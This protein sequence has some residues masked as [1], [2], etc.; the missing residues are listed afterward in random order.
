M[1]LPRILRAME[2]LSVRCNH[3]G[4]PL[5]VG[6][7][8]RFITCQFCQTQ[9]EVKHTSSAAFTEVIDQIAQKTAQMADNLKVIELQ[10][11]IDRLDREMEEQ[12]ERYYRSTRRGDRNQPSPV[13]AM[14]GAFIAL[15]T[16]A[17]ATYW[18]ATHNT[19]PVLP[20]VTSCIALLSL[21]T[22]VSRLSRS[23]RLKAFEAEHERK[24][25]ALMEQIDEARSAGR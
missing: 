19:P 7:K 18:F 15:P 9:L 6:E 14:V 4:A 10:N 3:C 12:R 22:I 13:G 16:S 17:T 1:D 8:A 21:Y 2:T 11:E 23:S 5:Q 24:R 25:E 20:F